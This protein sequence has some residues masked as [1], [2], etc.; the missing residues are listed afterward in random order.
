MFGRSRCDDAVMLPT[1]TRVFIGLAAV[2]SVAATELGTVF[3]FNTDMS[4]AGILT[5][6]VIFVLSRF[7]IA[8]IGPRGGT[9]VAIA[10]LGCIPATAIIAAEAVQLSLGRRLSTSDFE[11]FMVLLLLLGGFAVATTYAVRRAA[12]YAPAQTMRGA[13]RSAG[14]PTKH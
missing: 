3:C 1:R 10:S 13:C 2:V 12:S 9:L 7:A 5:I 6:G 14:P 8:R 11:D 4:M